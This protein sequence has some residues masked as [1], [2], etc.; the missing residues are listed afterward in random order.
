MKNNKYRQVPD[1][2]LDL[3]GFTTHEATLALDDIRTT[4]RGLLV[5]IIV[6]RGTRSKNGPVLPEHVKNYLVSAGIPYRQSKIQEGGEGSL[7]AQF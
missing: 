3:H 5:R 7:E 1:V 4:S 2:T 6:G